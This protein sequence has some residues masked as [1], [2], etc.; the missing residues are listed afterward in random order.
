MGGALLSL[1]FLIGFGL[2]FRFPGLVVPTQI[3]LLASRA[4]VRLT[5]DKLYP[6]PSSAKRI[7]DRERHDD[8]PGGWSSGR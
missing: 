2:L 4:A 7:D 5:A 3:A 1:V 8:A 6:A